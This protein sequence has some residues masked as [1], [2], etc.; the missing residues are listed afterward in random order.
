MRAEVTQKSQQNVQLMK[1]TIR[2]MI[3]EQDQFIKDLS[4]KYEMMQSESEKQSENVSSLQ[5]S[6]KLLSKNMKLNLLENSKNLIGQ[7]REILE[8]LAK[9][10]NTSYSGFDDKLIE[11]EKKLDSLV[12]TATTTTKITL[13]LK[14][15]F[16]VAVIVIA[17]CLSV[18]T[19]KRFYQGSQSVSTNVPNETGIEES[20]E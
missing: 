19:V 4:A 9:N 15:V 16:Y 14:N 6:N 17:I 11:V 7:S 12:S 20:T 2:E 18:S 3:T 8:S 13:W 5:N 1:Q 10:I